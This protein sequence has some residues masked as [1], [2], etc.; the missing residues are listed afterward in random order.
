MIYIYIYTSY[1]EHITPSVINVTA[2][3]RASVRACERACAQACGR[4]DGDMYVCMLYVYVCIYIE[5]NDD[6]KNKK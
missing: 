1:G 3:M 6:N 5:N 4:G 2:F